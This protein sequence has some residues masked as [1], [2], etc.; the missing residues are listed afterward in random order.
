MSAPKS[1]QFQCFY[2]RKQFYYYWPSFLSLHLD[3][4]P[5]NESRERMETERVGVYGPKVGLY[6]PAYEKDACGV[7]MV[8]NLSAEP[9]HEVG[10]FSPHTPRAACLHG[11][12]PPRA[13]VAPPINTHPFSWLYSMQIV[14][15]ALELLKRMAHRGACG[16]DP[17]SGDGAGLLM[18]VPD[19]FFRRALKQVRSSPLL[20][21]RIVSLVCG[22]WLSSEFHTHTVYVFAVSLSLF[23]CSNVCP[24]PLPV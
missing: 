11:C 19:E 13:R 1:L 6:D 5:A 3:S 16:C 4:V 9:T 8:A 20:N 23:L 2:S 24:S 7:G 14:R 12:T 22:H 18:G 21:L 15:D 10:P 17:N